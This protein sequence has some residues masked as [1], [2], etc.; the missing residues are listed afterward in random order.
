MTGVSIGPWMGLRAALLLARGRPEGAFLIMLEKPGEQAARARHSFLAMAFCVPIFLAIEEFGGPRLG[1]V[2]LREPATFEL[3][4]SFG[5]SWLGYAVLSH[6]LAAKMERDEEWRCF[7]VLW[8]WCNLVQYLLAGCALV[9]GLLG[10]PPIV[11]QTVWMVAIGWS[12][13]LQW[14]ATRIGLGL[15][16]GRAA[17][18]VAAD[19][20]LGIVVQR[21]TVG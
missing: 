19:I 1:I 14:S 18:M 2:V 5:L 17:L 13:W 15:S 4:L 12:I 11:G 20:A 9:P 16:G 7:L 6:L 21:L 8:N 3:A 10:A